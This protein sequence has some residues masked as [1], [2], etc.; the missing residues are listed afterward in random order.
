MA[1]TFRALSDAKQQERI[2]AQHVVDASSQWDVIE[3]RV[4][5]SQGLLKG[6]A[7]ATLEERR[8]ML[9]WWAIHVELHVEDSATRAGRN[10]TSRSDVLVLSHAA[11]AW[12]SSLLTERPSSLRSRFSSNTFNENG[13]REMPLRPFFS[14]AGR[15]K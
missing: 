7:K 1:A 15:L 11:K 12:M 6:W 2:A 8:E 10:A 14:A 13:N 3:E 9:G 4:E 5:E